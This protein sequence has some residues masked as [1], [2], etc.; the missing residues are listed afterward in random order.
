MSL[1][2]HPKSLSP[3][4]LYGRRGKSL[5]DNATGLTVYPHACVRVA[6]GQLEA[7]VWSRELNLFRKAVPLRLRP[8]AD[9]RLELVL[10][11]GTEL[12]AS[13]DITLDCPS[14]CNLFAVFGESLPEA[15]TQGLCTTNPDQTVQWHIPRAGRQHRQFA[16]RGFRFIRIQIYDLTGSVVFQDISADAWFAFNKRPGDFLCSDK[17]FLRT[18]QTSVYTARLCTKMNGYWDGIKRDR[19]GWF[20]DAR[21]IQETTDAVFH[22]PAPA[23]AMF[24]D[25][26]TDKWVTGIP[27][28]SLD[29]V[30]MLK[31]FILCHGL[32]HAAVPEAYAR[33]REMLRW[34][35]RTQTTAQGFITR[36][37]KAQYFGEIAFVDWSPIPVGGKFEELSWLQCKYVEAWN[38][39]SWIAD[40]LGHKQEARGFRE[41]GAT[42]ARRVLR[43]FWRPGRGMI[44][45]LN[46]TTRRW[47]PLLVLAALGGNEYRHRYFKNPPLGPSG[48]SRQSDALAIW[49]GLLTT[50][51][52]RKTVLKVFLSKKVPRVITPYFLYFEQCARAECGDPAGALQAM[53]AYVWE[54]VGQ[55]DSATVWE[56]Y[57]PAVQDF[58]KWA[59]GDWPKSLCHGWGSGLV[60]MTQR[61]LLGVTPVA[62]GFR[63]VKLHPCVPVSWPYEARIPT[64]YGPITVHKRRGAKKPEYTLPAG[65]ETVAG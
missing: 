32:D 10:D 8:D 33:A 44:H 11:F 64:P 7:K 47:E 34:S 54:Q 39:A 20:G 19:H 61:Y 37:P 60:P 52:M 22:D 1:Y 6:P 24:K 5:P 51:A 50:P 45:T 62:P 3:D 38:Q 29:A 16:Q 30:A 18:W 59:L 58:R 15:E 27:G 4:P 2:L 48:A 36:D 55:N 21:V 57:D 14:S 65:I 31:Q 43:T 35:Q 12:E 46:Q 53:F 42:L 17:D 23:A 25:L 56:W 28:Y 49:A 9:G 26:P 40:Q 13:L 41:E 63:Q